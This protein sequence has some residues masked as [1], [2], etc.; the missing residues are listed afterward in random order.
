MPVERI[1]SHKMCTMC[2]QLGVHVLPTSVLF[3]SPDENSWPLIRIF[4]PGLETEDQ[5]EEHPTTQSFLLPAA[6][7]V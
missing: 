3:A 6:N 5:Q 4:Q 7:V 1:V 2:T